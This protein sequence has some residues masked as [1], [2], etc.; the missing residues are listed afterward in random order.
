MNI[1]T[2][3]QMLAPIDLKAKF[4]TQTEKAQKLAESTE[5]KN[6]FYVLLIMKLIDEK[7]IDLAKDFI[8]FA[9]MQ[10][11]NED[12]RTMDNLIAKIYFYKGLIYE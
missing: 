11:L 3:D 10:L 7:R 5:A 12:S 8:D 1:P 9:S 2:Y 6:F 4:H